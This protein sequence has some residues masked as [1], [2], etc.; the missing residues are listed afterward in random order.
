MKSSSI[1]TALRLELV[2]RGDLYPL[3]YLSILKITV[4]GIDPNSNKNKNGRKIGWTSRP[5][6]VQL[7]VALPLIRTV[8]FHEEE[9]VGAL[10]L[11]HVGSRG[12]EKWL[13][14]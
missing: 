2:Q 10:E 11:D 12:K 7:P 9:I 14:H 3:L 8:S 5:P 6:S 13:A 1:S 4:V